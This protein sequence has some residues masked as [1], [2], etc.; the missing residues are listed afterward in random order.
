MVLTAFALAALAACSSRD[1]APIAVV[2]PTPGTGAAASTSGVARVSAVG[3]VMLARAVGD[4]IARQGA[5]TVFAAVAAP[6]A[7]ADIAFANL[8][9]PLTSRGVAAN[10]DFT[11]RAPASSADAL[12]RSDVV[13][14]SNNHSLDYGPDGLADTLA[15]LQARGIA[16]TGAGAILA[17]ALRPA[18]VTAQGLRIAVPAFASFDD[19]SVTGYRARSFAAT[20]TSAG[21]AWA[22]PKAIRDAVARAKA[23]HDV[24]IVSMHWG[25][26]YRDEIAPEQRALAYA[27]VDAGAT[28]V[29]GSGPPLL[30]RCE[31]RNGALIVYSLGNLLFDLDEYDRAFP[32]LPSTLSMVFQAELTKDGVRSAGFVP[33]VTDELTGFPWLVTRAAATAVQARAARLKP[34]IAEAIA[35]LGR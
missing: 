35:G 8:E 5:G 28:L 25:H 1:S 17:D 21:I 34:S 18:T 26:E 20:P 6:I 23:A 11:F 22:E 16:A 14:V 24:V 29:L 12:A 31:A 9:V 30:Q 10:K 32:G 3:D 33:A 19:D 7:T 13:S 15:A 2:Q 4:A 27:A